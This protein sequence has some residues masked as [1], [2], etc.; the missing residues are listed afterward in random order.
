MES[1]NNWKPLMGEEPISHN[2][3]ITTPLFFSPMSTAVP[4]PLPAVLIPALP[5]DLALNILARVPRQYHPILSAVS[6]SIRLAISSTQLFTLRSLL[7]LTETLLYFKVGSLF[8][9]TE[10]WFAIYQKPIVYG[11][12]SLLQ[13]A[14]LLQPNPIHL[15]GSAHAVVG[16]NIYVIGGTTSD[17][18]NVVKPSSDVWVLDCRS[19]TWQRGPSMRTPRFD[20]S[21]AVVDGKI[22]VIGG[23][24]NNSWVE[25]FDPV[26]VG[27]GRWEDIPGPLD[28][29]IELFTDVE[30]VDGRICVRVSNQEIRLDPKTTTWE[31]TGYDLPYGGREECVVNGVFHRCDNRGKI[32]WYDDRNRVWKELKGGVTEMLPKYVCGTKLVNLKGRLVMMW[33]EVSYG[34]SV[35]GVEKKKKRKKGVVK[36]WCGEIEVSKNGDCRDLWGEL[37]QKVCLLPEGSWGLAE[38]NFYES[39]FLFDGITLCV[40][41]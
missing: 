2:Y 12:K 21:T 20:A 11:R 32:E 18:A 37:V 4:P 6:K 41:L 17:D 28:G 10:N 30:V 34:S 3:R 24:A 26:A 14:Q 7:N 13:F 19:H 31:V 5:N 36:L 29:R 27:G 38:K 15:V 22:Y 16:P 25:V 35:N 40:S 39:V 1:L 23:R 9:D 8:L 33:G